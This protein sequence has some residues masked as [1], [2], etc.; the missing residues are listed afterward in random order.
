MTENHTHVLFWCFGTYRESLNVRESRN[1]VLCSAYPH[2]QEE[3]LS[4]AYQ[5]AWYDLE[6]GDTRGEDLQSCLSDH[7]HIYTVVSYLNLWC[8][9]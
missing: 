6:P 3:E 1:Y 9:I 8:D 7:N 4:S 5:N 2:I